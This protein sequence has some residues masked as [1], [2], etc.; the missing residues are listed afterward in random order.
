MNEVVDLSSVNIA[1]N[2]QC[3]FLKK[4][5]RMS[6]GLTAT[7]PNHRTKKQN[8]RIDFRPRCFIS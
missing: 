4:L 7:V 6:Y 8:Q 5:A 1:R 2:V 3:I